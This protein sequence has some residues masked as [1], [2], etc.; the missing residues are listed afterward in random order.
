MTL[1]EELRS[2]FAFIPG[3]EKINDSRTPLKPVR[4]PED[5]LQRPTERTSRPPS[6]VLF[7]IPDHPRRIQQARSADHLHILVAEDD[8]INSKIVKKRLEKLGHEVYLTINGEECANTHGDRAMSFD[9]VLMD[10][11][12]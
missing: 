7:D 11:Q 3:Q 2:A 4:V 1:R 10:L 9:V 6:K 12:V 8:P 5:D